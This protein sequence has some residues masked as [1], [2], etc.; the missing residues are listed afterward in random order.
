MTLSKR[1]SELIK[2]KLYRSSALMLGRSL[3]NN[4]GT[5]NIRIEANSIL[6]YLDRH[7]EQHK[8]MFFDIFLPTKEHSL[9]LKTDISF[10]ME[11]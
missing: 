6:L 1:V 9:G 8:N 11:I 2:G 4:T 3:N 5:N 10:S 7:R